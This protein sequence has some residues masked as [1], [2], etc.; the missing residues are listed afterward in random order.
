M[1]GPRSATVQPHRTRARPL[2]PLLAAISVAC[3][4]HPTMPQMPGTD[5]PASVRLHPYL[6]PVMGNAGSGTS[7]FR[8]GQV[9]QLVSL[10]TSAGSSSKILLISDADGASTTALANTIADAGF[11]VTVRQAPEYTWDATN[12]SLEGYDLVIHLNGNTVGEGLTLSAGAQ[13]ALVDFVRAGGGFVGAQWSGYEATVGQDVMQDLVLMGFNGPV[14]ENCFS[15]PMTYSQVLGQES[16]PVLAGLP[17]SFTFE[18]DGHVSGELID[19]PTDASVV[20]MQVPSGAAGVAVRSLS[21]GRIV[22]F[23]FA[24]NYGLGGEGQTLQ[25]SNIQQ[26][27]LNAVRWAAR[28]ASQP[29]KLP[30]TISLVDPV[31]TFDGSVKAVSVTTNPAGL[32]GVTVTYSQNGFPVNAP[33]NAGVY[34]VS[35]TLTNDDYEAPQA[36]GS[37]TILKAAPVIQ[38]APPS[39]SVGT[40]LGSAQL[41]AT[42]TGVGGTPLAGEFF[43]LPSAG[44]ILA[45]GTQPL[46][47]EF[48]PWDA[49]YTTVIK[50]VV[51]LVVQP[52]SGLTF[53]GFFLPIRNMPTVNSVPAGAAIPVKFSVEGALGSVVLKPGSPSSVSVACR[54]TAPTKGI[55]ELADEPVSQLLRKGSS[56][57]YIWKT[58]S[59]WSGSCRKLIL[60]LVDGSKHEALFRFGKAQK[61]KPA[62]PAT[63]AKNGKN[64]SREH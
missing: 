26:L 51:V 28:S 50:T 25:N 23:S 48:Q 3:S 45:L 44:T 55:Q 14:E 27:Y 11:L 41:N 64:K 12:P 37:L 15:C 19:F 58:N 54:P 43:Y 7:F 52:Q 2:L 22:H 63:L 10:G 56:F 1:T 62:K 39:I 33:V 9:A 20:L 49:N 38:W 30:A 60:T 32:A 53:R 13:T 6:P 40:P 31:S 24:P 18:A 42:A 17:A 8:V 47:V 61:A 29:T 59:S 16:H 34:E 57:T 4:E 21:A 5:A 35:A 46:S 36:S